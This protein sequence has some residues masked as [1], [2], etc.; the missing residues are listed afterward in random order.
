MQYYFQYHREEFD[1][2][3]TEVIATETYIEKI[4]IYFKQIFPWVISLI[5]I[6]N[7]QIKI[8]LFCKFR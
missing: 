4:N 1:P 8:W 7:F 2:T 5:K 6:S 3:A